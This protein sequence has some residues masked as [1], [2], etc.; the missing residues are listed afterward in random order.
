MNN[1]PVEIWLH[2]LALACTDGGYTGRSL[3]LVSR[4]MRDVVGPVRFRSVSI[5]KKDHLH[6]LL[7]CIEGKAAGP[8]HSR[9]ET[10][11]EEIGQAR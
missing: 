10:A 1:F 7:D 9:A 3:C 8:E 4:Q 6:A 5:L 2:I 11:G